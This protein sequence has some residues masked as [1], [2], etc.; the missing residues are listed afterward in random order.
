[1]LYRFAYPDYCFI[2]ILFKC[3]IS[4]LV[5]Y[6]CI[7]SRETNFY[8]Q[9]LLLIPFAVLLSILVIFELYKTVNSLFGIISYL[10]N[11][12]CEL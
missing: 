10:D 3:F 5:L 9:L 2:A 4:W 12:Q 7:L 11:S 1:M 6:L 8:H